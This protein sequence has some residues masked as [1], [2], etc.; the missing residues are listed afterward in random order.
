MHGAR[1]PTTGAWSQ[2]G[3]ATA[4]RLF[5][6]LLG[7]CDLQAAQLEVFGPQD[8]DSFE[9]LGMAKALADH[10]EGAS[11][12]RTSYPAMCKH[13]LRLLSWQ[14]GMRGE[15][16][17]GVELFLQL[18]RYPLIYVPLGCLLPVECPA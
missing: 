2:S 16:T 13:G 17:Y 5:L 18:Q 3:T 10:L 8:A 6:G 4:S 14:L 1:V 15:L 9:G 12:R 11:A 7:G